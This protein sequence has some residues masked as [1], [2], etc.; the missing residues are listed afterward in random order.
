MKPVLTLLFTLLFSTISSAASWL[1]TDFNGAYYEPDNPGYGL[2]VDSN[3]QTVTIWVFSYEYTPGFNR[4]QAWYVSDTIPVPDGGPA[5][6]SLYQ[7]SGISPV[8]GVATEFD[9]GDPV[10]TLALAPGG[11]NLVATWNFCL[12]P[13]FSPLP[14]ACRREVTLVPVY[15]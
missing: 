7:P 11:L 14:Q 13:A 12:E 2:L 10:A 9:L 1:T 15:D 8:L 4:T 5:V 3:T 6:F